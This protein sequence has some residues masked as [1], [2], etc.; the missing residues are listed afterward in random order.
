M[1]TI[2]LLKTMASIAV[3]SAVS[4]TAWAAGTVA[5][6][7]VD[8]TATIS[9]SVGG[10][11][12]ADIGSSESGNSVGA[13]TP[14]TFVVDKKVD[15]NVTANSAASV[16]IIPGSTA[17]HTFTLTNEGNDIE[18]FSL[19][20]LNNATGDDFDATGCTQTVTAVTG[21]QP[22][23]LT[24]T[25]ASPAIDSTGSPAASGP[26]RLAADGTAT[27]TVTCTAPGVQVNADEA[28]INLVATAVTTANGTT[29]I[30]DTVGADDP[31]AKDT[32]RADAAGTAAGDTATDA[33][34]SAV[35]KFTVNSATLNVKKL[36]AVI[37]DTNG[38]SANAKRIPGAVIEY[39]ITVTN[40]AAEA[41]HLKIA[42]LIPSD[43]TY[44]AGGTVNGA[45]VSAC[46][47]TGDGI[48]NA[49]APDSGVALACSLTGSTVSTTSFTL[50]AGTVASPT[51]ATLTFYATVN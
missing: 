34:H 18:Y 41:D 33:K 15:L 17:S 29:A 48:V 43:L 10:V 2:K 40:T 6:T 37:S 47:I 13:G 7:D 20:A 23:I 26:L 5:G 21:T 46:T 16:D 24:G 8:N 25:Y 35:R 19:S 27:I 44:V 42:D 45:A 22:A 3:L 51:T 4:S 1:K 36:S 12:Q 9:Y 28:D 38:V 50:P 32:V 14:T 11:A 31:D 39:T 49:N 30:E